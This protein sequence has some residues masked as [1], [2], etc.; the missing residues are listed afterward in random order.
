MEDFVALTPI[1]FFQMH[2]D[3]LHCE[4]SLTNCTS[5]ALKKYLL[6]DVAALCSESKFAAVAL[7]WHSDGIEIFVSIA[8]PFKRSVYPDLR[9]G[10]SVEIFLDTRDVKTSG[11]NTKFCHHFFFLPEAI[12]GQQ[13]GEI[14]RFRTED[15][16]ELCDPLELKVQTQLKDY[17]Y[18]MALSLP[19]Q[20]L[21]GYEP[22][23]FSRLGFTYRLN[24]AQGLPQH[25][26]ATT[27]DYQIEQQPSLWSSLN[28][29]R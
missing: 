14:T 6:P 22:A 11:Y 26:S 10:D 12:E 25:F 13:A 8:Q 20:V 28:L 19:R 9:K 21:F 2:L 1:N 24:R 16:H 17:S 29:I 27:E 3:C 23:Q 18:T 5:A 15:K 7:G 4:Q